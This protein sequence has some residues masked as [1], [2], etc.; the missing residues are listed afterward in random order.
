[1]KQFLEMSYILYGVNKLSK[2]YDT[3]NNIKLSFYIKKIFK[4]I[5]KSI[6]NEDNDFIL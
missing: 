1:M 4:F 5:L 3:L 2:K 6:K